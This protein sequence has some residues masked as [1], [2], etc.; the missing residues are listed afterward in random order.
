[1]TK[2]LV[3]AVNSIVENGRTNGLL[4]ELDDLVAINSI[5]GL[6]GLDYIEGLPLERLDDLEALDLLYGYNDLDL[7]FEKYVSRIMGEITPRNSE[8]IREFRRIGEEDGRMEAIDWYYK[9][10]QDSKY[11]RVDQVEKNKEWLYRSP[12]GD[13]M[14]TINLSKPEKDPRDIIRA[15]EERSDKYPKCVICRENI[16]Y[17]GRPG[18]PERS[19]HRIIPLTL[20][21]ENWYLQFS[22]YVYYHEHLIVLSEEHSPMYIDDRTLE[23]LLDFVDQY[24]DLFI[25]SNAGLPIVGGSI[26]S[27]NHFQ[28]GNYVFPIERARIF[29]TLE[30][31]DY[32]V[33]LL[34][35]PV[36]TL[37]V[38]SKD[39]SRVKEIAYRLMS[40][41]DDYENKDL[42]IIPYTGETK[43]N[44]STLVVRRDQGEYMVYLSLRN[45][46]CSAEYPFGIFH[47][48]EEYHH[49]KKENIGL[50]EVMGMAIL[51][52]RLDEDLD[53][54]KQE[55]MGQV[56]V[57]ILENCG[58][59]KRDKYSILE[60]EVMRWLS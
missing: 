14:I 56:F 13:I 46:R 36:T 12:Y 53:K 28:G 47:A 25:G 27:H 10:S 19:N 41:W 35:W 60:E 6:L 30:K 18:H 21:E 42:D 5:T 50:I 29:N 8:V 34:D 37:R 52:A 31:E 58:V 4:G 45:N 16:G 40:Q 3:N 15:G 49:I 33:D 24:E 2:T 57:S 7:P 44:T 51:P 11:I 59:F 54:V 38:R 39:R 48:H 17:K 23:R 32:Q 1:M 20:N 22:P 26:L 55:E 43:H 9:L